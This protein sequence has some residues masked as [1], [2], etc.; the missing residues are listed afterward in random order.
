ML[1]K[2]KDIREMKRSQDDNTTHKRTHERHKLKACLWSFPYVQIVDVD[3]TRKNGKDFLRKP[4]KR[5]GK[6]Q[7]R[8]LDN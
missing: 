2:N 8:L 1:P 5:T 4:I 6:L 7:E 3:I